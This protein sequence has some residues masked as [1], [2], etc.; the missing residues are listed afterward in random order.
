M[1]RGIVGDALS[2][3]AV[4]GLNYLVPLLLLPYLL[5]VLSPEGYG[6]I[7]FAQSLVGYAIILTEFGF[8]LTAARDISVARSDP[9]TVARIYWTTVAAKTLLLIVSLVILLAVTAA[10]P[11]F[12]RQWP[13]FAASSLLVVGNVAFPIWYFQ[14]LERLR[15]VAVLQAIAK[16]LV[17][18]GAVV[19]VRTEKDTWI[20]ALILATPQL[21]GAAAA[22]CLRKRLAPAQFYKPSINDILAAFRHSSHMFA[23]ILSTTLYLNTNTLFLG[24][25][26]G[27]R[28]VALY[29]VGSRL[30][31]ALQSVASPIIQSVF[32]RASLLFAERPEQAW[33]L[34]RRVAVFVLP[35]VGVASLSLA[36][37]A[38]IVVKLI[39][40]QAY[41]EASSVVRI[42]AFIPLLVTLATALSQLIMVNMGLTRQLLRI[43]VAVGCANLLVL[44]IL[45]T[46]FAAA[47]AALALLA[48]EALG[49]ILMISTLRARSRM[50]RD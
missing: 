32:P 43:Y 16:C 33:A 19:L 23:S 48:A 18:G 40:G 47:G 12:R 22:L 35:L 38:P 14:G 41:A 11:D 6:S 8:N 31:S 39:G 21:M 3:Y 20:A 30:V 28:A 15:E 1:G 24:I 29:S 2:L 49:P 42:M 7:A 44:P 46:R 17:A 4:Q 45:V 25:L 26:S 9:A 10:T 27:E 37:F 36:I 50:K 34:L 13:I 5:R